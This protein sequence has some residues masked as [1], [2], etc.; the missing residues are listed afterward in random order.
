[1]FHKLFLIKIHAK[2]FQIT[3]KTMTLPIP[4]PNL[5]NYGSIRYWS[6]RVLFLHKTAPKISPPPIQSF[7]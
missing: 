4:G 7:F 6:K 1:M 3:H 5:E 2:H